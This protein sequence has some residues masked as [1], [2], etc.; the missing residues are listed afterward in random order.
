MTLLYLIVFMILTPITLEQFNKR[1]T[2]ANAIV[3]KITG[4]PA[5]TVNLII[6]AVFGFLTCILPFGPGFS[7]TL[8]IVFTALIFLGNQIVFQFFIKQ[9]AKYRQ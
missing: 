1:T 6:C 4:L 2:A 7:F 8:W 9:L 5:F 3:N